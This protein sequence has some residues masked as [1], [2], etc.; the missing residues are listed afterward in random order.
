MNHDNIVNFT[1]AKFGM[2][3]HW[4]LYAI[5]G[6]RWKGRRMDYIGEW[7]Q[8]RFRIPNAEYAKL[9]DQFNPIYFDADKWVKCAK[10]AGMAYIVFTA[11]HHDGFAMYRSRVDNY[12]IIDATPFGRDALAEL[13]D[14][15][16]RHGIKLGIYYSHCLDWHEKDG[17]APG[18]NH[19][20]NFGMSWGNDWDFPNTA[21]KCFARYFNEKALPQITELLT[22][23]GPVFLMW[24]DCPLQISKKQSLDLR[25][26]VK[27]LQPNC[28]VNGR[29]GHNM[30]DFGCLGDNQ[31]PAGKAS[32]PLE[33]ANTLNHTWG[34]KKDDH[35]WNNARQVIEG[36][37][38]N[39]EKG[40]NYLLNIGP[41]ADGK[42]PEA[43]LDILNEIAE[44][45]TKNQVKIQNTGP[46]PFPHPF[47]W[48][49]CT[50]ADHGIQLFI[51]KPKPEIAI[52][53]LRNPIKFCNVPFERF[54]NDLNLHLPK[55]REDELPVFVKLEIAGKPDIDSIP[56]LKDDTLI[57][58]P[59]T[60]T[61]IQGKHLEGNSSR[62]N[63]GAAAEVLTEDAACSLSDDGALT[64]WH[65]PGDGIQWKIHVSQP[66]VYAVQ[67]ITE[68]RC[69][70]AAWIGA[71]TVSL[72]FAGHHLKKEL[73]NDS[74]LPSSYYARSISEIGIMDIPE[75]THGL[76]RLSSSSV[77]QKEAMNMNLLQLVLTKCHKE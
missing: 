17:A 50:T 72:E 1:Q 34:Y 19:T 25:R 52:T 16:N 70:S 63:L 40:V 54:G 35:N 7:I 29:I 69:H 67:L 12:N 42:F 56:I 73:T 24:F 5:P 32:R 38:S 13:A 53:G 21:D 31:S 45:R 33:S 58:S 14:A 71:R 66:G 47:P 27:S 11:K 60:G 57:L 28:L 62:I 55:E 6:G 74:V 20:K 30:G 75:P 3:I 43:S 15:C 49:H 51:T 39:N 2:F 76:L 9:A 44:W 48:G 4:G 8:S 41:R 37:A 61:L 18:A 68:N 10:D 64:Q 77:N 26:M 59:S 65:H 46:N 23:Y 36:L 22:E